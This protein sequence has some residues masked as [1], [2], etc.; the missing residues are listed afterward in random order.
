MP[1]VFA[2]DM[3]ALLVWPVSVGDDVG[4]AVQNLVAVKN[5]LRRTEPDATLGMILLVCS[6]RVP[7]E[8]KWQAQ[9]VQCVEASQFSVF[10]AKFFSRATSKPSSH[11]TATEG[12]TPAYEDERENS[13]ESTLDVIVAKAREWGA[14]ATNFLRTAPWWI[15]ASGVALLFVVVFLLSVRDARSQPFQTNGDDPWVVDPSGH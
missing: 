12:S 3:A 15:W 13:G 2:K 8:D 9:G 10:S 7:D 11:S 14:I 6:G 4:N 1:H 5:D